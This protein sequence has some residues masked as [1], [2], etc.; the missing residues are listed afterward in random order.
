MNSA[1]AAASR[2]TGEEMQKRVEEM[3]KNPPAL[4]TFAMHLSD[5]KKVDGL[6]LP[7]KIVVSLDGQPNEEWTV[8]KYKVN[9]TIKA[10]TWEKKKEEVLG[11]V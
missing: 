5:Y 8:E 7:H 1:S 4:G 2:W 10:D 6:M 3:R 11:G 9:P